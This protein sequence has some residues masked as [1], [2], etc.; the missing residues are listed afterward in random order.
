VLASGQDVWGEE[1]LRRS[2]GPTL[3]AARALLPPLYEARAAHRTSLTSSGAYYLPFAE[4]VGP[5]GAGAV[6][7]HLADGSEIVTGRVGGPSLSIDVGSGGRERFGS[8]LSRAGAAT[9]AG[10]YLP[11]LETSYRDAQGAAYRQESFAATIPALP[12]LVSFVRIRVDARQLDAPVDVRFVVSA[13]GVSAVG[14]R[15]LRG[16]SVVLLFSP[17]GHARGASVVYPVAPGESRTIVVAYLDRPAAVGSVGDLARLYRAARR[18][19]VDYWEGRLRAGGSIT[20]P[21]RE[22]DDAE[23]ALL[24]Q[25]LVLGYRYSIGNAYRWA[26]GASRRPIA[27]SWRSRCAVRLRPTRTGRAGRSSSASPSTTRSSTTARRSPNSA[28]H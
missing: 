17:G 8:C 16:R 25:N 11:I 28:R 5:L 14:G 1:L 27:R 10:G 21:E 18:A 7:L 24:I 20:V 23:R 12:G 3:A 26:S 13:A 4:P 22:V 6:A 2:G 9:L 19:E 15:L